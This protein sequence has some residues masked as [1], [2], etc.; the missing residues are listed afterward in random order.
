MEKTEIMEP[1][2]RLVLPVH[3]VHLEVQ[4]A[5]V[6]QVPLVRRVQMVLQEVPET[7]ETMVLP[8]RQ[9]TTVTMVLLVQQV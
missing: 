6:L 1:L 8:V 7:T 9:E 4:E 5:L 2:V 3:L